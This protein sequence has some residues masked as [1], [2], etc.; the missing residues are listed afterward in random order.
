MARDAP[1]TYAQHEM[2]VLRLM[3]RYA[4][5]ANEGPLERLSEL[6]Y[7]SSFEGASP[8]TPPQHTAADV[9]PF[10]G[11]SLVNACAASYVDVNPVVKSVAV[12]SSAVAKLDAQPYAYEDAQPEYEWIVPRY[13]YHVFTSPL[14]YAYLFNSVEYATPDVAELLLPGIGFRDL[15]WNSPAYIEA[16]I[17]TAKEGG[18]YT[19]RIDFGGNP[20]PPYDVQF[21]VMYMR[22]GMEFQQL[23][24]DLLDEV[25]TFPRQHVA[26]ET[27]LGMM[28][29]E[30]DLPQ[31]QRL[32]PGTVAGYAIA[33]SPTHDATYTRYNINAPLAG[34]LAEYFGFQGDATQVGV[35][36][37]H[38]TD[39]LAAAPP[40][41]YKT[42]ITDIV[43]KPGL[44]P[45]FLLSLVTKLDVRVR[46]E[47][48]NFLQAL[49]EALVRTAQSR[50]KQLG[51]TPPSG[52]LVNGIV[53]A[54]ADPEV[55]R[56]LY[57]LHAYT[58]ITEGTPY[59]DIEFEKVAEE[60]VDGT[61]LTGKQLETLK[62]TVPFATLLKKLGEKKDQTPR[63]R[64]ALSIMR[65]HLRTLPDILANSSQRVDPN[66]AE[67]AS[68]ATLKRAL[69]RIRVPLDPWN[70]A[71]KSFFIVR[72]PWPPLAKDT[73]DI[74]RLI[75]SIVDVPAAIITGEKR[76]ILE[77][78]RSMDADE[79]L[80]TWESKLSA[81]DM[82]AVDSPSA[83]PVTLDQ[84]L[85]LKHAVDALLRNPVITPDVKNNTLVRDIPN[86]DLR[87][88]LTS[89]AADDLVSARIKQGIQAALPT[90]DMPMTANSLR[91]ILQ[92]RPD[93][94]T[95]SYPE[96][97]RL[98]DSQ[99]E[100][101][102][103]GK[104]NERL[105]QLRNQNSDYPIKTLP[106][107]EK[108]IEPLE[109]EAQAVSDP[110]LKRLLTDANASALAKAVDTALSDATDLTPEDIDSIATFLPPEVLASLLARAK[111]K[112]GLQPAT[113][114]KVEEEAEKLEEAQAAPQPKIPE[115]TRKDPYASLFLPELQPQLVSAGI[116][117]TGKSVPTLPV[118]ERL[119]ALESAYVK[120]FGTSPPSENLDALADF[121]Q[122]FSGAVNAQF[123]GMLADNLVDA[124]FLAPGMPLASARALHAA[125][126][127][128]PRLS[129][130]ETTVS[131]LKCLSCV[132]T[133]PEGLSDA[134]ESIGKV[135]SE[136]NDYVRL[137]L[138]ATDPDKPEVKMYVETQ[139]VGVPLY[140]LLFDVYAR[141]YV[142]GLGD[143]A[144]ASRLATLAA[145][146]ASKVASNTTDLTPEIETANKLFALEVPKLMLAV[147]RAS[148]ANEIKFQK[149]TASV[150]PK[151]GEVR[152]SVL[153][154][155]KVPIA[156]KNMYTS[157]PITPQLLLKKETEAYNPQVALDVIDKELGKRPSGLEA[158]SPAVQ[159]QTLIGTGIDTQALFSVSHDTQLDAR[160]DEK[161][162][163]LWDAHCAVAFPIHA[164]MGSKAWSALT[165]V[166]VPS[167]KEQC[168]NVYDIADVIG[169]SV[170]G[171]A[172]F[173]ATPS[174][175]DRGALILKGVKQAGDDMPDKDLLIAMVSTF[176]RNLIA[177]EAIQNVPL[178][179]Y[180]LQGVRLVALGGGDADNTKKRQKWPVYS[181]TR[182][183]SEL[184]DRGFA[185]WVTKTHARVLLYNTTSIQPYKWETLARVGDDKWAHWV[186]GR[187][188]IIS[189]PDAQRHISDG[190]TADSVDVF[191]EVDAA[192]VDA[193]ALPELTKLFDSHDEQ[194]RKALQKSRA[195]LT[196]VFRGWK[197][198][199]SALY[200]A[201]RYNQNRFLTH[202]MLDDKNPLTAPVDG[203][204]DGVPDDNTLVAG[205]VA[206]DLVQHTDIIEGLSTRASPA[207]KLD[208]SVLL[209]YPI[210]E[211]VHMF[212]AFLDKS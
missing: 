157:S 177:G 105:A 11:L 19:C 134:L 189:D 55:A 118:F 8:P 131:N 4:N 63:Q 94:A 167:K 155:H 136:G 143:N 186:N 117:A 81:I 36:Q 154:E 112:G 195:Q 149:A 2:D 211:R 182:F 110:D 210:D 150:T 60:F 122:L 188:S 27:F 196:G 82:N 22:D 33:L 87:N 39:T 142:A 23:V 93:A 10:L 18:V 58:K 171:N 75:L 187:V 77:G 12:Q 119:D 146:V 205:R 67:T 163:A 108:F 31:P 197:G 207:T 9:D 184:D 100:P 16:P 158:A 21:K 199:P 174:F 25:T 204:A 29:R 128:D 64:E 61:F 52:M 15:V 42:N 160:I 68:F 129:S 6:V 45:Y 185:A 101:L 162:V 123:S 109:V 88:A 133:S 59:N 13:P 28:V 203:S 165:A 106:E 70:A 180:F 151:Q 113:E 208:S 103:S 43:D 57:Q 200:E 86:A 79:E 179:L 69:T 85:D 161:E 159:V 72:V 38:L 166:C 74:N 116:A 41:P 99:L 173:G 172:R 125:G 209:D 120:A 14:Y 71:W 194:Q 140:N 147:Y 178:V 35:L 96:L 78:V 111:E 62:R 92:N 148:P 169:L 40:F 54:I 137:A 24:L 156:V 32:R 212:L 84:L 76:L 104:L 3:W 168:Y 48:Q 53:D 191:V 153:P 5:I 206:R 193:V 90:R 34:V 7:N 98:F 50:V 102:Y 190:V 66:Y 175:V 65:D 144:S 141:A 97:A 124:M 20:L 152:R 121:E 51:V 114:E 107:F 91:N 201:L 135:R 126:V 26:V 17:R 83:S 202:P 139:A 47:D 89:L 198:K 181:Y 115:A 145:R 183:F 127:S 164:I 46:R 73:R 44:L 170:W 37:R 1:Q 138:N 49:Y 132:I 192:G 80:E 56:V 30:W 95:S 130:V 176:R